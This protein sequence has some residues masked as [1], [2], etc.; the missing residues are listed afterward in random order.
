MVKIKYEPNYCKNCKHYT[1][2][3]CWSPKNMGHD[4]V[5]GVAEPVL[6]PYNLRDIPDMC[7]KDG[8]WFERC[9]HNG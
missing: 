4:L 9:D 5:T 2:T 6:K 1:Y 7:G 8:K 3:D